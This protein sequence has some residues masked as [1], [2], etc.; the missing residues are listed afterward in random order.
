MLACTVYG[1][2][3]KLVFGVG[4]DEQN[5]GGLLSGASH[6]MVARMVEPV[7]KWHPM[8]QSQSL[9]LLNEA[10]SA[11]CLHLGWDVSVDPCL[12]VAEFCPLPRKVL[13]HVDKFASCYK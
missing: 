4:W 2:F 6:K 10:L 12:P 13:Y 1:H 11:V 8:G 3:P 9:W 7:A 5:S